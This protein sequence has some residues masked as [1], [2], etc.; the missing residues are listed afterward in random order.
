M[1]RTRRRCSDEWLPSPE[2]EPSSDD[3]TECDQLERLLRGYIDSKRAQQPREPDEH[4][5]IPANGYRLEPGRV[6]LGSTV[7]QMGSESLAMS[8]LGRSSV[9]RL[10][11]FLNISAD[12]GE[13]QEG[14]TVNVA[15]T[16]EWLALRCA[17]M[18]ARIGTD[19]S[20]VVA[21]QVPPGATRRRARR[22]APRSFWRRCE[23]PGRGNGNSTSGTGLI[24]D[25]RPFTT[26]TMESEVNVY[27]K[28]DRVFLPARGLGAH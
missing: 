11:L 26:Y 7:E 3:T 4:I 9:G 12:L 18:A 20:R 19:G 21:E 8:L 25:Y 14:N 15:I 13:L 5:V 2:N 28:A 23:F 22:P 10:G 6:Y 17:I 24:R 27:L 16:P 1:A